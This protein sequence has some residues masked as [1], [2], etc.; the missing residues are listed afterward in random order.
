MIDFV[1]QCI[2]WMAE[3]PYIM[4]GASVV[5]IFGAFMWDVREGRRERRH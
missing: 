3:H 5:T 4:T 1:V 2:N